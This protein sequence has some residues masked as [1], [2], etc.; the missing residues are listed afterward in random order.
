M[1][2]CTHATHALMLLTPFMCYRVSVHRDGVLS[3]LQVS[4]CHK[5]P[6]LMSIIND[7]LARKTHLCVKK[8]DTTKMCR[9]RLYM[10]MYVRVHRYVPSTEYFENTENIW[11]SSE[12][13]II[14]TQLL[15]QPESELT[16]KGRQSYCSPSPA[17]HLTIKPC[18]KT[19]RMRRGGT[20][21]LEAILYLYPYNLSIQT[22]CT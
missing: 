17:Q 1:R 18:Q 6:T 12:R 10:Y 16:V 11:E 3:T 21:N 14:G 4:S 19:Q 9:E 13:E 2:P 8:P 20:S 5:T 15:L 7:P 22:K